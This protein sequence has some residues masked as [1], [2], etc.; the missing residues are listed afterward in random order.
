V[1]TRQGKSRKNW[2]NKGGDGTYELYEARIRT[3][4]IRGHLGTG[5]TNGI[6]S[7]LRPSPGENENNNF[8]I[9]VS[10]LKFYWNLGLNWNR[11]RKYENKSAG[12]KQKWNGNYLD[13]Y[14]PF[15]RITVFIWYFIVG[16]EYCLEKKLDMKWSL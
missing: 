13:I 14:G 2:T 3:H 10:F 16:N 7:R 1:R 9:Q 6:A 12:K 4:K 8:W 11:Y 5:N 15:P